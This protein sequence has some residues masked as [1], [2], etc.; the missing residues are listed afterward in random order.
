MLLIIHSRYDNQLASCIALL[1]ALWFSVGYAKL[2][3][4]SSAARAVVF[5]VMLAILYYIAGGAGIIFAFLAMIFELFV[6]QSKIL[7]V[8]YPATA[9]GTYFVGK[10]IFDIEFEIIFYRLLETQY[11]YDLWI[12]YI[13]ISMYIFFPLLL[14]AAGWWRQ[15]AGKKGS[16]GKHKIRT[17]GKSTPAGGARQ[18][19]RSGR[20]KWIMNTG[21]LMVMVAVSIFVSF[22]RT[23]KKLL[24]VDYFAQRR[25]WPEVLETARHI[26]PES[27]DNFCIHDVNRA[28]HCTG[29][30]GDEMFCYPQN[31]PALLLTGSKR[32]TP[33]SR[34]LLKRSRL[35]LELGH[36]GNAEKDAYEYMEL[37]GNSPLILEQLAK[38]KLAKGQVEAAKVFWGALSKDVIWGR[39]GREMLRRLEEDPELADDRTI[40]HLRSIAS[41]EDN[42]SFIFDQDDFFNQLLDKNKNNKMAFEY[43]MAFYLLAGQVDMVV[44]NLGHLNDLGYEKLPQY[45]EEA[46]VV[47][48]GTG[49]PRKDLHG[50]QP[51]L[52]IVRRAKEVDRIYKLHGG[53]NNE[54]GVRNALAAEFSHS[55]FEYYIFDAPR[56]RQ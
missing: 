30:F 27:Y 10:H 45:Y 12:M 13:L 7:S 46:I 14:F 9:I 52:E 35:L 20:G 33:S 25:M 36:V 47:Y 17:K 3:L 32:L 22:D 51:R 16:V 43:M 18:F 23:K 39:R 8:L 44:A 11:G 55:Y 28:L 34:K 53:R 26:R 19:L 38:I 40:Q 2:S 31:L 50:W 1:A 5:L 21:L 56:A 24:Q 29:R 48:M 37:V 49:R 54:Q 4:R 41:E 6:S 15:S 42:V